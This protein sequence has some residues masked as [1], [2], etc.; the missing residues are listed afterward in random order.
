MH[1]FT[2]DQ[3][4]G[5]VVFNSANMDW[6]PGSKN[7]EEFFTFKTIANF[8]FVMFDRDQIDWNH[9]LIAI[10]LRIFHQLLTSIF[11]ISTRRY[12]ELMDNVQSGSDEISLRAIFQTTCIENVYNRISTWLSIFMGSLKVEHHLNI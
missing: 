3:R 10:S 6:N 9:A 5:I 7:G 8:K 2:I 11:N 12:F 1:F 4:N